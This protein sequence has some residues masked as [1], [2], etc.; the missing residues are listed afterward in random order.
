MRAVTFQDSSWAGSFK[1]R[2]ENIQDAIQDAYD[3]FHT[4]FV[5]LWGLRLMW[6]LGARMEVS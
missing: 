3:A 1:M 5:C 4:G 6:D 2:R